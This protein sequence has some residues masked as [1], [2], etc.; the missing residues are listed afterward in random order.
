MTA[1]L[2]S[3]IASAQ[4]LPDGGTV[5]AVQKADDEVRIAFLSFQNNPF[6]KP[7]TE[8][9]MAAKQYLAPFGGSLDYIDLG[10]DLSA[11]AVVSGIEAALAQQYDGIVVVP[12]FNGT[13]RIINEA[14]EMG[15]PVFSIIAEG[16]S[17]SKR[18]AFM[19]QDATAAGQQ[20]GKFIA[21][22][23]DGSGKLGVIT[24]Y[25]GATQ[26]QMRM[27]GAL[28]YLKDNAPN[29]EIIGPFENRDKAENAYSIVQNMYTAN[30]DLEMVY[31]TAGGPYGAAKAVQ[32]L[33]LTG[34][35]GVVGFDHTPDNMAY[36]KTGEMVGL[37]DQAPFQQAFDSSVMLFNHLVAGTEVPSQIPVQGNLITPEEAAE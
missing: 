12:I 35:V 26:H 10:N 6:W 31:V 7:V 29:I 13:A 11:E 30:P 8:G 22:R 15:V 21:E 14:T 3:G 1:V 25:F 27:N 33:G 23:M 19:G 18:L 28:D 2:W 36:L 24:G 17:P 16:S 5:K 9:A 4:S 37:L 20:I 32:D 34:Q